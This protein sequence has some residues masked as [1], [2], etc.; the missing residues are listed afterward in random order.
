MVLVLTVA[1]NN[2]GLNIFSFFLILFYFKI[3]A[4]KTS[5]MVGSVE[6]KRVEFKMNPLLLINLKDD[7]VYFIAHKSLASG[8]DTVK[9]LF[10]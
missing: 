9:D 2:E 7:N 3:I 4:V 5:V 10:K 8:S 6:N 1:D